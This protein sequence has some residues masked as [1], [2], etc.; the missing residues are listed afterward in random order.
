MFVLVFYCIAGV[1]QLVRQN[2]RDVDPETFAEMIAE[3]SEI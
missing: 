3:I 2:C 1:A